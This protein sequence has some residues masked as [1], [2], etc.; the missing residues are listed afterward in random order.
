M[1]LKRG[2]TLIELL[3]VIAIIAILAAILFPVFAQAREKARAINCLS[4][5]KQIGMALMQYLQDYDETYPMDQYYAGNN[6]SS[7]KYHIDFAE[8]MQPYLKNGDKDNFGLA[9]GT[10]GAFSCP[11]F[12]TQTQSHQFGVH[13][14]LCPDGAASW[15]N[16]T[17]PTLIHMAAI[18][19]PADKIFLADKGQGPY[20]WGWAQFETGEWAWTDWYGNAPT[21][22]YGPNTNEAHNDL[23]YDYD[24]PITNTW[25]GAWPNPNVMPRY[26]HQQTCNCVFADG[27]A[28]AMQ[29]GRIDWGKNIYIPGMQVW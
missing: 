9:R 25:N 20:S 27:H 22:S 15:N 3:V 7:E 19:A 29:K 26:R 13:N 5:E 8:M 18:D 16:W 24:M 12:P 4:N 14:F 11:S 6:D 1:K 2:F 10:G 21:F 28:K 17:V 23:Q